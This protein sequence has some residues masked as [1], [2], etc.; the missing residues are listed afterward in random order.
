MGDRAS[1]RGVAG[2]GR[3]T[4]LRRL[5]ELG[6]AG[7]AVSLVAPL[8]GP[9]RLGARPGRPGLLGGATALPPPTIGLRSLGGRF[10]FDPPGLLVER[11]DTVH[12]LNIGDF[13][14]VTTFHP[15]Y[16]DLLPG[17]VPLRIPEEAEPF[18][19]GMLGLDAGSHFARRFP[20]E[21]VYDYF[22]QPHYTFGMVGRLVVGGPRGGPAL[23]SEA[24]L[25]E[26]AREALP[27]VEA[28]TETPGRAH[29]WA[30]RLNGVLLLRAARGGGVDGPEGDPSEAAA[31][32]ARGARADATLLDLLERRGRRGAFLAA[33]DRFVEG[34][35]GASY[36][37]LVGLGDAAKTP[38]RAALEGSTAR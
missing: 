38:L 35:G 12:W 13:H 23:R 6:A 8:V 16:A 11:G 1:E 37:E 24:E 7:A 30:A 32:V 21:G 15:D 22:C 14:T 25:V 17:D 19:S 9:G 26:A 3:R 31:A 5:G 28:I 10:A 2:I 34:G 20:V 18:H 27:S 4:F 36:D 33:L 29:L